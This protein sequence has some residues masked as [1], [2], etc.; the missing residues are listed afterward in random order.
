MSQRNL[1]VNVLVKQEIS[2]LLHTRYRGQTVYITITDVE[3]S[4]DLRNG[5]VY[6]SVIGGDV[7]KRKAEKFFR[8][9]AHDIRTQIGKRIVLKYLPFLRY[10]YDPSIARGV[11][12]VDLIDEI[13]EEEFPDEPSE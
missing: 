1:R 9:N 6:Y 8:Q 7:E 10:V 3:I 2:L 12:V 4:P 5:R 13:T 11:G